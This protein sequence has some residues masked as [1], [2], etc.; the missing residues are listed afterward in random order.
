[1]FSLSFYEVWQVEDNSFNV[2]CWFC[3]LRNVLCCSADV[4]R[5]WRGAVVGARGRG[6]AQHGGCRD[7]HGTALQVL[8]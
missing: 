3:V 5:V 8:R 2:R 4:Q 7:G 6:R 1:M